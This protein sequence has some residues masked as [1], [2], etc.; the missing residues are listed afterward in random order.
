MSAIVMV[1]DDSPD[2][3]R[4][5]R[6]LLR[7]QGYDVRLADNGPLALQTAKVNPPDVVLLDIYMPNMDGYEVCRKL[8]EAIETR[9]IPVL[10]ISAL[11]DQQSKVKAFESG[12]QDYITKPI[13]TQE[14][15]A[16]VR[17]QL[18][19]YR[20]RQ[21][22]ERKNDDLAKARD[23]LAARMKELEA[24]QQRLIETQTMASLGALVAGVAHEINTP[25]GVSLTAASHLA[26]MTQKVRKSYDN[27]QLGRAT[28]EDYLNDAGTAASILLTNIGRAVEL[29]QNFK[30]VAVDQTSEALRPIDLKTYLNV[31]VESLSP[32]LKAGRHQVIVE[33]PEG[34]SIETFPGAIAQITSNL[35][36]NSVRHGFG[37]EF[38]KGRI[39]I[40]GSRTNGRIKITYRDNGKGMSSETL[41]HAF[42]PFYTTA[43]AQ[44]GS[45]LGL[46]IVYNLI[47]H[48]LKGEITCKSALREGVQTEISF[49]NQTVTKAQD[50]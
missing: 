9:D 30:Q 2:N 33:C 19:L 41:K 22:L 42:E 3:L 46:S 21:E 1:V 24:A 4:V 44:G 8:R 20:S 25:L 13:Q 40:Q 7:T 34:I 36:I 17:T 45:G 50:T 39:D 16:R 14:V 23:Q 49:P 26:D 38:R 10:F 29:V 6:D 31:V 18:A 43:R 47:I 27:E 5:M 37:T 28:F 15:L 12:G 32:E 35:V 48:K 11:D